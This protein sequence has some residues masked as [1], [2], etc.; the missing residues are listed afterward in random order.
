MSNQN[1]KLQDV[2]LNHVRKEKIPVSIYL[3][4]GTR[5]KGTIMGFDNF[6]ILL[7]Q[8]SHQLVYKHAISTIAPEKEIDIKY[9]VVKEP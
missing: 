5:L 3:T 1:H 4:N 9:D 7:K 2:F 8:T 6:C